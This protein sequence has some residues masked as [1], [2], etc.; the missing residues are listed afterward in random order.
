MP[1]NAFVGNL[2]RTV[3]NPQRGVNIQSVGAGLTLDGSNQLSGTGS[4]TSMT[5]VDD[6]ATNAT[7]FLVWVTAAGA[8]TPEFIS[9]AAGGLNPS[10]GLLDMFTT[11]QAPLDNSNKLASTAY[12][13]AA[14]AFGFPWYEV[15]GATAMLVNQ[16]YV[17]NN[18][19]Q[20]V[21]TLP[22]TAAFGSKLRVVGKGAGG[23]RIAQNV[24]QTI[25]FGT[26]NTTSGVGGYLESQA[27]FDAIEL[28][29]TTADT[30][31]TELSAQGNII[32]T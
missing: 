24:G 22:A 12:V 23:W 1:E 25:H 7:V 30:N 3:V 28:L 14:V 29:C 4:A 21:L 20:V 11:P 9:T 19:S 16:G 31:W 2:T 10:T 32:V 6:N 17:A 5:I 18:S 13:D 15:T 8:A 26:Q 27:T